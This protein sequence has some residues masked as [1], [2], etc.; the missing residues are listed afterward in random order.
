MHA[1]AHTKHGHRETERGGIMVKIRS[2]IKQLWVKNTSVIF[3]WLNE[4]TAVMSSIMAINR[5]ALCDYK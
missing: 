4:L 1:C 3:V 5:L 2:K